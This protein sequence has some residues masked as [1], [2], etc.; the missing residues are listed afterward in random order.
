[1]DMKAAL[2]KGRHNQSGR[3]AEASGGSRLLQHVQVHSSRPARPSQLATAE[4]RLRSVLRWLLHRNAITVPFGVGETHTWLH[5]ECWN[6]WHQARRADAAAALK[7]WV[8]IVPHQPNEH[9]TH[10]S[11]STLPTRRRAGSRANATEGP[12]EMKIEWDLTA[13]RD[14]SNLRQLGRHLK[15][16]GY[17]VYGV[18]KK[19]RP[20]RRRRRGNRR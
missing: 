2:D 8:S 12:R 16:E 1:M 18:A 15:K 10:R 14:N 4:G 20:A 9:V 17:T 19:R 5:P 3:C 13:G 11:A 6:A 7:H